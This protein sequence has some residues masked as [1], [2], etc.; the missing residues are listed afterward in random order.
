MWK[1]IEKNL[2]EIVCLIAK[3]LQFQPEVQQKFFQWQFEEL[4]LNFGLELKKL[5]DEFY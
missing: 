2:R 5:C 1:E 4:L 3:F